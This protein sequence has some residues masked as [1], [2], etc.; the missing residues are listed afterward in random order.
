VEKRYCFHIENIVVWFVRGRLEKI[1]RRQSVIR[2]SKTGQGYQKLI[3]SVG[4]VLFVGRN[5]LVRGLGIVSVLV[6]KILLLS[7]VEY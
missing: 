3:L 1:K 7:M 2:L 6:V 5:L 4:V